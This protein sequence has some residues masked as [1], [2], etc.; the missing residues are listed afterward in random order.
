MSI[1]YTYTIE[2]VDTAARCM[3]VI[4]EAQG[5][6]TQHVG[7]RI[8]FEGETLEDVISMFAPVPYWEDQVRPL[9]APAVGVSGVISPVVVIA[10]PVVEE[11]VFTVSSM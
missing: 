6:V 3:V 10:E 1:Q 2:S 5:H 11:A 8:P 9:V 4:Y 7:T